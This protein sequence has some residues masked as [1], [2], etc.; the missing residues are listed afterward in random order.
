VRDAV[1]YSAA[2][3]D[4]V[5]VMNTAFAPEQVL[6]YDAPGFWQQPWFWDLMKQV[7]AGLVVLVLVLGLLRPTLKNLSSGN[8]GLA[9]GDNEGYGDLDGIEGGNSLRQAM[10]NQ[11]DLLLPGSTGGYDRQLNALKGLIA[12]DPA[13]VSQVM[14][15]WVNV[16]D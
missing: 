10:A 4:S 13:R 2:R 15:Q 16:D 12:E 11:D 6:E 3:G 8:K 9:G 1:G 5:T 14:R 7:L